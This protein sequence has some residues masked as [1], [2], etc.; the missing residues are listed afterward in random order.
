M[1]IKLN[2]SLGKENY[3]IGG[4]NELYSMCMFFFNKLF[5]IFI[6]V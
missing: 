4:N 5:I 1:K 2:S 6:E 3:I